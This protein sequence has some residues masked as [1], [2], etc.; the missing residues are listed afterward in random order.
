M[1]DRVVGMDVRALAVSFQQ[2]APRGSVTRFCREHG[3]S[4][5]WFYKVRARAVAQGPLAALSPRR[6]DPSRRSPLAIS[7]AVE[8]AA[9]LVRKQLADAGWDHGPVTVRHHLAE[10]GLRAPAASTLA[11]VFAR[12]GMVTAQPQKRPR[13]ATRRFE[14]AMVHE[15]WQLDSFAWPLAQGSIW[16]VYQ[17]IDDRSRFVV[18]SHVE[19]EETAAGAVLV[20]D[21]GI[22]AFQV[23]QILLTDNGSA[24]NT[25]RRGRRSRLVEHL[26]ALG[27]RSIT[28]RPGHPQTQGKDERIHQTVQRWLRR[29][30]PAQ[31]PQ[32]LQALVEAFDDYYNHHRPHQSLRMRTPAQAMA[33]GPVAIEPTPD[34]ERPHLATRS[35]VVVQPRRVDA[36]GKIKVR[37]AAILLGCEHAN[38]DVTVLHDEH[39]IEVFDARG[40]HIRSQRLEPGRRYYGNGR[41]RTYRRDTSNRPD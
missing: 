29:Q 5:S 23:P 28:G 31:T 13:S 7:V 37:Y 9:V 36:K 35:P 8:E 34:P 40:T 41:P 38:T 20:L 15:C 1:A 4:R 27:G 18:A 39:Q 21:K 32:Q 30:P 2:D 17:L 16:H 11:R 6:R 10:R 24:F 22:G 19:K 26:T 3:V 14:F 25:T 33:D 12:R